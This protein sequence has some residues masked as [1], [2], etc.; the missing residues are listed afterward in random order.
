MAVLKMKLDEEAMEEAFFEET[1][2]LGLATALPPYR[3]CWI[4]NNHFDIN[5]RCEPDMTL[6]LSKKD[7]DYYYLMYE[8]QLPNSSN[9]Y[10]LYQLKNNNVSLLPEISTVDY[11]WLIQTGTPEDDAAYLAEELRN[12]PD[13]Q[14]SR[15]IDRDQLK[16]VKSLLV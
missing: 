14:F 11:L 8:Y 15:V 12:I 1:C 5:F 2:L 3:L 9:R 16:N 4:L 6:Q 10:L 7:N 13:I